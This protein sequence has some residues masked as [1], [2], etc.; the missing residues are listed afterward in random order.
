MKE[1]KLKNI[2]IVDQDYR[3]I[4]VLHVRDILQVLLEESQDE[5]SMLRDYVM[6]IGY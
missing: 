6:G 1:H 2:P 4:G 3:P 5:E